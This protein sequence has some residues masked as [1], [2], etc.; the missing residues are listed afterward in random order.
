MGL[1]KESIRAV[2]SELYS[3]HHEPV[4]RDRSDFIINAALTEADRFEQ[5]WCRRVTSNSF[6]L[7]CIPFFLYNV[8]LGDIVETQTLAGR[9][10][11]VTRVIASSG[12]YVFRV[13]FDESMRRNQ[14][15]VVDTLESM[16][17]L[18]EWSSGSLLA[19]DARDSEHA[20]QIADYL[21]AAEDQGLLV[22]ETGKTS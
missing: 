1:K 16:S 18:V 3:I 22:Y 13:H 4:W 9:A 2:P 6:E 11:V 12:R 21:W 20:Q 17:S 10:Y 5:L 15:Q 14:E 8:A 7:C 19:V